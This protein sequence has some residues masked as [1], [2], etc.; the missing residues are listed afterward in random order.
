[1]H[2]YS[3][4]PFDLEIL[5]DESFVDGV[6]TTSV[7][8]IRLS[9]T[10]QTEWVHACD[11]PDKAPLR[12]WEEKI[13]AKLRCPSDAGH[14]ITCSQGDVFTVV[15]TEMTGGPKAAMTDKDVVRYLQLVDRKLSI[16][17]AGIHWKPE[18]G[19]ELEVIDKEIKGL[20]R[21]VDQEHARREGPARE[22]G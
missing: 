12:A 11:K 15:I 17:T 3:G 7:I 21:S 4:D 10:A 8:V 13:L 19:P 22:R 18:Y 14:T 1:M 6:F 20:R 16:L 2:R 5:S 9:L